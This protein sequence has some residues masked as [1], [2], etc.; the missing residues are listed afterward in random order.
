MKQAL[1]KVNEISNEGAKTIQFFGRKALVYR[2]GGEIKTALSICTHLGGPLELKDGNLTCIWHGAS[3]DSNSG[4]CL[5]GP[6]DRASKAM[7]SPTQIE[8]DTLMY[9]W[10][11]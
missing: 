11:E 9:V 2:S 10:G 4:A 1:C 3:F 8:D 6:A 7:F 5:K